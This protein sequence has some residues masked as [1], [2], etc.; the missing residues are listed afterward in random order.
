MCKPKEL[1]SIPAVEAAMKPDAGLVVIDFWAPWCAPC[2]AMAPQFQAAA[3][4]YASEPVSFFKLDTEAHPHLA[5]P[6]HVR[7]LPT[8]VFALNGEIVDVVV[9]AMDAGRISKKVDGWLAKARGES[10]WTRLFNKK[11]RTAANP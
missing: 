10:L 7:S 6:F 8:T 9:G 4:H 2:R 1:T 5:E 11:P 3:E